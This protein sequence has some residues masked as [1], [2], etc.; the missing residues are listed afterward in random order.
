MVTAPERPL[1]A[2]SSIPGGLSAWTWIDST[3]EGLVAFLLI[4]HPDGAE[5]EMTALARALGMATPDS[6]MPD[7]GRRLLC[8]TTNAVLQVPGVE[9]GVRLP[10]DSEWSRFI[11]DGATVV[12]LISVAPLA[13][14]ADLLAVSEHLMTGL[15]SRNLWMGKTRAH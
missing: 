14:S 4:A 15:L 3:P 2:A 10:L 1:A 11:R 8:G 12:L 9:V 5:P 13:P 7:L 6:P